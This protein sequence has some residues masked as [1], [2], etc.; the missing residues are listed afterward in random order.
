[1]NYGST[2]V[3][4]GQP[5]QTVPQQGSVIHSGTSPAAQQTIPNYASML[6]RASQ[7]A[8][9]AN[10]VIGSASAPVPGGNAGGAISPSMRMPMQLQQTGYASMPGSTYASAP[11][12]SSVMAMQSNS[13]VAGNSMSSLGVARLP[14]VE[15]SPSN[16]LPQ[17]QQ[18][19]P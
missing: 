10:G 1:M 5:M 17:Q 19:Q 13:S 18:Q 8:S 4:S 15:P 14:T 6:Q 2:L 7:M 16:T 12:Q 9:S 3:G 11:G